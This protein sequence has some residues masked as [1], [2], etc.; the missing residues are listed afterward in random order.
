MEKYIPNDYEFDVPK[1]LI[2]LYSKKGLRNL[3]KQRRKV[4]VAF[5]A[6]T[7]PQEETPGS[8]ALDAYGKFGLV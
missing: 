8:P 3:C 2:E 5:T 4:P 1:K 7:I 6:I